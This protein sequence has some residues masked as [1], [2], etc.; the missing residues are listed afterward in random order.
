MN[1]PFSVLGFSPA[2]LAACSCHV[3]LASRACDSLSVLCFTTSR[4]WS[5]HLVLWKCVSAGWCCVLQLGW[6]A[7]R[8]HH[9]VMVE[10]QGPAA[11]CPGCPGS[12]MC[13][14]HDLS[15]LLI[16]FMFSFLSCQMGRSPEGCCEMK[17]L[18]KYRARVL[19]ERLAH[20]ECSRMLSL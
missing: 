10:N 7:V 15:R 1:V 8:R 6:V 12:G 18:G 16:I 3:S 20:V 4:G 5:L 13:R 9:S 11:S 2:H 14:L 19:E 17:C